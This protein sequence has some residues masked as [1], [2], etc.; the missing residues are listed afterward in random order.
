[1][2]IAQF[3]NTYDFCTEYKVDVGNFI[4]FMFDRFG[5]CEGGIYTKEWARAIAD[6]ESTWNKAD[7]ATRD[8]LVKCFGYRFRHFERRELV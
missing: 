6:G 1:M 8:S 3:D 4:K 2:T 5:K 7:F